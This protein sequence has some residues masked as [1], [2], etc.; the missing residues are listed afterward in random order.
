MFKLRRECGTEPGQVAGV[1]HIGRQEEPNTWMLREIRPTSAD[2]Q[3]SIRERD[4]LEEPSAIAVDHTPAAIEEEMEFAR[5]RDAHE[6]PPV[7]GECVLLDL[8]DE[9][10][11]Q[12]P[13]LVAV[14]DLEATDGR[15][16]VDRKC[17]HVSQDAAKGDPCKL[18]PR[19][20]V[21]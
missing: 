20:P 3:T 9:D 16:N 11:C 17:T 10:P 6:R 21:G 1:S 15:V 4:R 5:E 13:A 19:R 18:S 7:R 2:E 14:V 12:R 8:M